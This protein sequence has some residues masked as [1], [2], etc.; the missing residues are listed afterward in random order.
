M[1]TQT[2]KILAIRS[3]RWFVRHAPLEKFASVLLVGGLVAANAIALSAQDNPYPVFK[4]QMVQG[5]SAEATPLGAQ[6]NELGPNPLQVPPGTPTYGIGPFSGRV[7]AIAVNSSNP[8][9]VYVGGAQGG[10]WKSLDGGLSWIPLTDAQPSLATGAIAIAPDSKSLYVGSGESS[11]DGS[12]YYGAGLLK[13]TDGGTTWTVLGANV[14]A[15]SAISS[16]VVSQQ[17]HL[18]VSTS[19]SSCCKELGYSQQNPG[20]VGVFVSSDGGSTWQRT[21]SAPDY[22]GIAQTVADPFSA[23][24]LYAGD[25]AANVWRSTDGGATWTKVMSNAQGSTSPRLSRVA[26]AVTPALRNALFAA[27]VNETGG[28]SKIVRYDTSSGT[29]SSLANPPLGQNYPHSPCNEACTNHLLLA[30]D[31]TNG[32]IIYFGGVD[33]YR[34]LDAGQSWTDLGGFLAGSALHPDQRGL[35]FIPGQPGALMDVNDGGVW[36][37]NDK[38]ATWTNLNAGLPMVQ[39]VSVTASVSSDDILLGGSLD[40]GWMKYTGSGHWSLLLGGDTGWTGIEKNPSIMYAEFPNLDFRESNDGGATWSYASTG[41]NKT[42]PSLFYNPVTQDT[43]NPG[44]LYLGSNRIYKTTNYAQSWVAISG[45]LTSTEISAVAIAPSNSHVIYVGDSYKGNIWV[46]TNGGSSWTQVLTPNSNL[47]SVSSI[48]V[49][50]QNSSIAFASFATQHEPRLVKTLD[51]GSSWRPVSMNAPP[52]VAVN[53]ARVSPTTGAVYLG[54]DSGVYVSADGGSTWAQAGSGLPNAAI[55]DLTFTAS[56]FL[57][58]ATHGRGAWELKNL[59]A[60]TTTSATTSSTT[61]TTTTTTG[62]SSSSTSSTSTTTTSR[63]SSAS[64]TTTTSSSTATT[65]AVPEFPDVG[66]ALMLS[67]LVVVAAS[68]VARIRK[69]PVSS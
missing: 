41:I 64:Q 53:I 5:H 30:V 62:S 60:T 10:V 56:G 32:S 12:S 45:K 9:N 47:A 11:R 46:T 18:V 65:T 63:S 3:I 1:F 43:N 58:A 33:L 66:L 15:N 28:L 55:Y 57:V 24:T 6:W 19:V 67:T 26:V 68:V 49:D 16:V 2:T 34:S 35:V 69:A 50:P 37:S 48:A 54:T 17:N 22:A 61:T 44:T 38:G 51:G 20:G 21:L 39:L 27:F 29:N 14:F 13:S 8:S 7:A 31:P 40:L 59:A 25:F 52:S 23:N 42:D 36:K 4:Q